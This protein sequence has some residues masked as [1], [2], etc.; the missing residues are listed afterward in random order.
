MI[1]RLRSLPMTFLGAVSS[2]CST[3]TRI[4]Y[5]PD[6]QPA[7]LVAASGFAIPVIVLFVV[8]LVLPSARLRGQR[9]RR[10]ARGRAPAVVGA[11]SLSRRRR[12]SPPG[13]AWPRD[14]SATPTPSGAAGSSASRIIALSLVPLVGF[15]GQLSLCQMSFAGIG[16]LVHG[17]PR[18][19]AATRSGAAGWPR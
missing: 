9:R 16:A 15:A 7:Y 8:L 2:A 10:A 3:P 17:P 18:R 6:G 12:S 11:A 4:G 14:R 13:A 5:L 19:R 1:G